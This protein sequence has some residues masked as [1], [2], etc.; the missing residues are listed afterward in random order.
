MCDIVLEYRIF[1][2]ESDEFR[3]VRW[4]IVTLCCNKTSLAYYL[5][6]PVKYSNSICEIVCYQIHGG[7]G[8]GRSG[9]RVT[10]GLPAAAIRR[11]RGRA[12]AT[13]HRRTVRGTDTHYIQIK[14][15]YKH[16][17]T[18]KQF[19]GENRAPLSNIVDYPSAK[20]ATVGSRTQ[21][22]LAI[23]FTTCR[24]GLLVILHPMC[25]LG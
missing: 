3:K 7:G 25:W 6:S 13:R 24:K 20:V 15:F 22:R 1:F 16:S 4:H 17:Q 9:N 10:V 21:A 12:Q 11:A 5:Q 18:V 14:T 8:V 23:S 2:V 19:V